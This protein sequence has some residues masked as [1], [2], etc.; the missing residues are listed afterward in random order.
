MKSMCIF[1]LLLMLACGCSGTNAA[2]R[3][4]ENW[5]NR[6]EALVY[7]GRVTALEATP[8]RRWIVRMSVDK[9]IQG[10]YPG[11]NFSFT[12]HSPSKSGL[13]LGSTYRVKA[14]VSEFGYI[15]D[16]HQWNK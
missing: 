16:E 2:S 3:T 12:V 13:T 7:E 11:T 1:S 6:T 15:V 5:T 8:V 14:D 9:I 4:V 10:Q